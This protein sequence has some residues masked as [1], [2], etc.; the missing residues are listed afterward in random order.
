MNTD[1]IKNIL[2]SPDESGVI[3]T[4]P[5]LTGFSGK[6]IVALLQNLVSCLDPGKEVYLEVGVFQ[7]LSLIS[8]AKVFEGSAFGIDNFSQFDPDKKN[9]NLIMEHCSRLGIENTT[10]INC[11]LEIALKNISDSLK[12]KKIGLFFVDGPHDYRSQLL[13]LLLAR[14]YFSDNAVIVIDDCNYRHV[15]Q[16][17]DDFL[18]AC[19]AFKLALEKYTVAHPHNMTSLEKQAATDGWWNGINV[20]IN[21]KTNNWPQ[22]QIRTFEDR[23]L[24]YNEQ[25]IHSAR[26]AD[27]APEAIKITHALYPLRPL[28][29]ISRLINLY[30]QVK[31]SDP[32][33][34]GKF[35]HL[36]T[37]TDEL[38]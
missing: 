26:H 18:S 9:Y 28:K 33:F 27:C 5:V 25:Y 37:Y 31:K 24:F 35:N 13:C 34:N 22:K 12:G 17:N 14:Q 38:I 7:G 16:A 36:N 15:R 1:K 29:L 10:L 4:D 30:I 20:L 11:D 3:F 8:V 21:D 19:P 6:K 32:H 23:V 2:Q